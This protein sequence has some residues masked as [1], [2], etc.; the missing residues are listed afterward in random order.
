MAA[1]KFR[2]DDPTVLRERATRQQHIVFGKA[3]LLDG[4]R[5]P[6]PV[7][8]AMGFWHDKVKGLSDGLRGPVAE[9]RLGRQVPQPD[10]LS[11]AI[12]TSSDPLGATRDPGPRLRAGVE[13]WR[14]SFPDCR[15]C[16]D[17]P[18]RGELDGSAAGCV[19][20][21]GEVGPVIVGEVADQDA[22]HVPFAEDE[23]VIRHSRRIEPMSRSAKGFCHGLCGAVRSSSIPMPF[24]RCRNGCP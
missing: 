23:H 11:F 9:H 20:V 21:Q 1:E 8:D 18:C 3:T 12:K 19:L 4:M 15:R 24:T 14:P 10:H 2:R 16:A 17:C 22:A 5:E 13:T 6:G 7:G